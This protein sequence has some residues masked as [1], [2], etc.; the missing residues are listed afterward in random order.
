MPENPSY[1]EALS[2]RHGRVLAYISDQ[3][4]H[5]T[6]RGETIQIRKPDLRHFAKFS[7]ITESKMTY[8][9]FFGQIQG[10]VLNVSKAHGYT[11]PDGIIPDDYFHICRDEI[12]VSLQLRYNYYLDI[13]LG[14]GPVRVIAH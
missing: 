5:L 7:S 12:V 2:F 14:P 4:N 1:L 6:N 13:S 10:G 9:L 8:T 3:G 11:S